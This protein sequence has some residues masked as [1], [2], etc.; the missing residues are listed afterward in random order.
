ML[1]FLRFFLF[2]SL[3]LITKSVPVNDTS[4]CY[5]DS[6]CE[7]CCIKDEDDYY[8]GDYLYDVDLDYSGEIGKCSLEIC[9]PEIKENEIKEIKENEIETKCKG[10]KNLDDEQC[11]TFG[12]IENYCDSTNSYYVFF[13]DTCPLYCC[14]NELNELNGLNGLNNLN[15]TK[16]EINDTLSRDISYINNQEISDVSWA[17]LGV[18]IGVVIFGGLISVKF[19]RKTQVV[20]TDVPKENKYTNIS[21]L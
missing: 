5:K 10:L 21:Y 7:F 18:I 8:S 1:R 9:Y 17:A 15:K 13:L 12:L 19:Y 16:T 4:I 2:S 3:I 20:D 14:L 11:K 6:D